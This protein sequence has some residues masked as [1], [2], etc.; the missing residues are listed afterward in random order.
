MC[1]WSLQRQDEVEDEDKGNGFFSFLEDQQER[2]F[3]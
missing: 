1:C 2:R 3:D